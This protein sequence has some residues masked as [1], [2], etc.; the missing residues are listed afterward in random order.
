MPR[1]PLLVFLFTVLSIFGLAADSIRAEL[2]A[3]EKQ[4][5]QLYAEYLS[6]IHI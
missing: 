5:E 1:R 3:K 2:D 4:L 6:L